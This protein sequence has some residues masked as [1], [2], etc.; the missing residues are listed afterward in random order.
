MEDFSQFVNDFDDWMCGICREGDS[1]HDGFRTLHQCQHHE[2]HSA[3]LTRL[4]LTDRRCPLCRFPTN[5]T[6]PT[7]SYTQEVPETP[8]PSQS[9]EEDT[10]QTTQASQR[11]R[12]RAIRFLASP[13]R[14]VLPTTANRFRPRLQNEFSYNQ[15]CAYCRQR[16]RESLHVSI[17][18]CDHRM[19][20]QC[21]IVNLLVNGVGCDDM[22]VFCPTCRH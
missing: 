10:Q 19:H 6:P 4:L 20:H 21:A 8:E 11:A 18:P 2:F 1:A 15:V 22:C 13:E 3:C 17:A 7:F 12:N 9:S 5:A 14:Q 16:I